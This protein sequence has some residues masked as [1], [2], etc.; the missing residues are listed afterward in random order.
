MARLAHSP[1]PA[2]PLAAALA[3]SFRHGHA[4]CAAPTSSAFLPARTGRQ[5]EHERPRKRRTLLPVSRAALREPLPA[6]PPV[7]DLPGVRGLPFWRRG[8]IAPPRTGPF[9]APR[10]PPWSR[11]P[12]EMRLLD[13]SLSVGTKTPPAAGQLDC[14]GIRARGAR[15]LSPALRAWAPGPGRRVLAG[16]VGGFLPD[17][18]LGAHH[19][20]HTRRRHCKRGLFDSM[21]TPAGFPTG[22]PTVL[23]QAARSPTSS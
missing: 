23:K 16:R 6:M 10:A 21:L 2:H 9:L 13:A 4:P 22:R 17:P 7:P 15:A 18:D 12:P 14:P 19:V 1:R 3:S 20:K 8:P 5:T 11:R